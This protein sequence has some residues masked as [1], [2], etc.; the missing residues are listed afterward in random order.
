M[1]GACFIR[2]AGNGQLHPLADEQITIRSKTDGV[3]V[4]RTDENGIFIEIFAP[5]DYVLSCRGRSNNVSIREGKTSPIR[6]EAD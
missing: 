3:F 6:L 1:V 2:Q 5:G 4:A